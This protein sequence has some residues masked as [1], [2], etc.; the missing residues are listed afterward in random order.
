[1]KPT[2]IPSE[3]QPG[4]FNLTLASAKLDGVN[5]KRIDAYVVIEI[6]GQ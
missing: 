2:K 6:N 5:L 3:F 1:L 4:N